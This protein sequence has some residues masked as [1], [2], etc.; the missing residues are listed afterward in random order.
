MIA[1]NPLATSNH[2]EDMGKE[3]GRKS[4]RLIVLEYYFKSLHMIMNVTSNG[5]KLANSLFNVISMNI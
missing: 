5:L 2:F 3:F 4:N 1:F